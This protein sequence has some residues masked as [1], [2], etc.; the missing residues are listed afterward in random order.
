MHT[1]RSKSLESA[2]MFATGSRK[3]NV[4]SAVRLAVCHKITEQS[5]D[6][7]A[8]KRSL[9]AMASAVTCCVCSRRTASGSTP[10]A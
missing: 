8:K 5:S 6:D 4:C 9:S 7:D 1:R 3:E 2:H 10:P